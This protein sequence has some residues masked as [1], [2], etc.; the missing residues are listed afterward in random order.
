MKRIFLR[1]KELNKLH[2][3]ILIK[4]KIFFIFK[5]FFKFG[6]VGCTSTLIFLVTY[7]LFVFFG[8]FYQIGNIAAFIVSSLNG[9]LLNK[10]LVFK[11]HENKVITQVLKYYI[12]YSSSLLISMFLSFIWIDI[13][14][15]NVF[16]A[17]LI[18][19]LFTVPYNF[20]L[21]KYWIYV[22]TKSRP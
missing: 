5:Q 13:C 17:P 2:S 15:I 9:F 6:L 8:C 19:L 4:N 7:D 12:V 1:K 20:I 16:I 3:Q 10:Y 22:Y 21:S 11:S 14:K 18:N